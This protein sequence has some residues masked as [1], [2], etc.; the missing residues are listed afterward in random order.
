MLEE[1]QGD[2][3]LFSHSPWVALPYAQAL[4]CSPSPLHRVAT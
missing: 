4:T 1:I 2:N 3:H